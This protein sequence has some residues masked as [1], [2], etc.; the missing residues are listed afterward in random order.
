M[1]QTNPKNEIFNPFNKI[2]GL[3][4]FNESQEQFNKL[5]SEYK[6]AS[7]SRLQEFEALKQDMIRQQENYEKDKT[8][9]EQESNILEDLKSKKQEIK[10]VVSSIQETLNNEFKNLEDQ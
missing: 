9:F 8:A 2:E 1:T 3:R 4:P 6:S 7:D 10:N 5:K